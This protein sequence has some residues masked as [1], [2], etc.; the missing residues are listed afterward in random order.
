MSGPYTLVVGRAR[1]RTPILRV[2]SPKRAKRTVGIVVRPQGGGTCAVHV[3]PTRGPVCTKTARSFA[4]R[5]TVGAGQV[6]CSTVMLNAKTYDLPRALVTRRRPRVVLVMSSRRQNSTLGYVNGPSIVAP[7]LSTLT[8]SNAL[9][10]GNCSS[11]PDDAPT[12]SNL[13][14]NLSP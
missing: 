6:F 8:R 12:H 14:A 7:G 9:F 2:T 1:K 5:W 3:R 13:L 10:A 4:L 11:T